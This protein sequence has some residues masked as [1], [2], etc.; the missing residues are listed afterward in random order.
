LKVDD[1]SIP[2][3]VKAVL[4]G[5]GISELYPPQEDA[6]KAGALEGRNLVLASPTASGKTLVAELCALKHV[7][8]KGGKVLYLTP[9]RALASEKY[10]EFQRW[11]RIPGRRGGRVRIG[12]STGDFDSS[13]PWLG[14]HNVIITTNEK[15]DSLLRHRA[16]WMGD[17]SLVVADEVHLLND[18]GRGPT[19]EVTLARMMQVNPKA[20]FLALSATIRNADEIADW[21]KASIVSTEWRPVKLVEGV[22]LGGKVE[23]N[24]GSSY[25]LDEVH[26]NSSINLANH[27]VRHGGQALVFAETRKRSVNLATNVAPVIKKTL[28]K[29]DARTLEQIS[30]SL[31][32]SGE[33]TRLGDQLAEHVK[34]GVAFHHA[35]LPASHRRIIENSFREGK[36]KVVVATPTLAAGVN[37]PARMVVVSSYMRYEAGYGR[38][39]I[40]VLEYKQMAG[41]A[42]RPKYDKLGEAVLI[43]DSE[44]EQDFLMEKYILADPEKI[45]SKL[46]VESVLRSHVLATIA[47]GFAHTEEGVLEFFDRTFYAYQYD[48]KRIRQPIAKVLKFLYDEEMIASDGRDIYPTKFGRRVSELYIDPVSGVVIRDALY[49]RADPLTELS[50]L[51][52]VSHTPDVEPKLYPRGRELKQIASYVDTHEGEFMCD[53]PSEW[54]DSIQY[55]AFLGEVK[56]A[57][58]ANTWTDEV[59]EDQIIERYGVEPGDLFRL[60]QSVDWLLF[61]TH[62]LGVLFGH[63][64]LLGRISE[65]RE[66]VDSG[67]RRELLPLVRLEGVGRVRGRALFSAG[68]RTIEDLKRAEIGQLMSVPMIGPR[69]AKRIKEQVGGLMKK[70]EWARLKEKGSEQKLLSS[71]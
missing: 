22:Y 70:E 38:Y 5:S 26:R 29:P 62:E 49:K 10:A 69:V 43:A 16:D 67:V 11:T 18:G 46:G 1:L 9:L 32:A 61:A 48:P 60:V 20:Q 25:A 56:C 51:H 36:I 30:K 55:E 15:A 31:L 45:W 6:I 7:V 33:R 42:G 34:Q 2:D 63:K 37:L 28:S 66:R 44:D 8:E 13:D 12:I 24:D 4:I 54:E 27:I 3:E 53:V 68:F 52:M 57:L 23:F 40:P 59:S 14:R 17:I 39:P 21:L 19:L 65:L 58:V 64:D 35:G 47:S 71:Y 50:F 41:R